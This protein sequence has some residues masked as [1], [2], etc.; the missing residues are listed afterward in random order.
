MIKANTSVDQSLL[1]GLKNSKK[2]SIKAIYDLALPAVIQWV[3]ENNGTEEDAR[4]IFQDA[5]VAL[6]SKVKSKDFKLT[7]TL[8]SFLRIMC[9]NLWLSRIRNKNKFFTKDLDEV[10]EVEM[11]EDLLEK[12]DKSEKEALYF[13]HFRELGESCREIL[14]AYFNKI[15]VKEI[16]EKL[17]TSESYIKK[18][19]FNCKEKLIKSIQ[20]DPLYLEL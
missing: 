2:E 6:F 4:D 12:I 5:I 3:K 19:K 1:E 13:K 11:G 18:R 8:K 9:R 16:A 10:E 17:K 20:D 7:C 15:P 14:E